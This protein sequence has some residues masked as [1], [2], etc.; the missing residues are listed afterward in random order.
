MFVKMSGRICAC[1]ST[2]WRDPSLVGEI[3][4]AGLMAAIQLVKDKP[5]RVLFT[6]QDEASVRVAM[7]V[8]KGTHHAGG[9]AIDGAEPPLVITRAEID[10][11]M[12][13]VRA[14]LDRLRSISAVNAVP[15]EAS[16]PRS[17]FGH[18]RG[19][20]YIVFHRG[21]GAFLVLWNAGVAV[22][23]MAVTVAAGDGR[24]RSRLHRVQVSDRKRLWIFIQPGVCFPG[25]RAVRRPRLLCPCVGRA[26]RR[27]AHREAQGVI[28]GALLMALGHFL[29]AFEAAFCSRCWP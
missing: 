14:G 29:M 6:E 23:Y 24:A 22:L 18:P 13:K 19:L 16:P 17:F 21:V 8:S 12:D 10:E 4:G 9:R 5:G 20:A 25:I 15:L 28:G 1:G 7:P 2:S 3:R 27:S 26:D 11:L